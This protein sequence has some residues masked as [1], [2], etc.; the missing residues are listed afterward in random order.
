MPLGSTIADNQIVGLPRSDKFEV[1]IFDKH[2]RPVGVGQLGEI[3][4][5]PK[6]PWTTMH[7]YSNQP[8]RNH[9]GLA[10]SM[11]LY[12]DAGR[13]DE[14]GNFY[15]VDRMQDT[16]RRRGENIFSMEVESIINQHP[17]VA[18]CVVF[19]VLSEHTEY[20]VL[21]ALVFKDGKP[22]NPVQRVAARQS[23]YR[24]THGCP[25]RRP[26]RQCFRH[27][28]RPPVRVRAHEH[29]DSSEAD[30]RRPDRCC[31]GRRSG[32]D[33][34]GTDRRL[35]HRSRSRTPRSA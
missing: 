20:E 32:V 2:D 18:E 4:V 13:Y 19:P 6:D 14:G 22:R 29:R 27:D 15:F 3:V 9:L 1:S 25:A 10:E 23:A 31:S 26:P 7:G 33:L 5:R 17:D 21:T 28:D 34:S 8:E 24:R 30:H 35:A 11:V 12:R 16:I